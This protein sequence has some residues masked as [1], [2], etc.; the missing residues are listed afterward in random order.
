MKRL[1]LRCGALAVV[2]GVLGCVGA[3]AVLQS[4]G[5]SPRT[6]APY[7]EKRSSGHRPLISDSGRRAGATLDMLD[8][9]EGPAALPALALGARPEA[10]A[11]AV[12]ALRLVGTV[13]EAR[14]AFAEAA[15]GDVITFAPGAYRLDQPLRASRPGTAQAPVTVRARQGGSVTLLVAAQEGIVVQAPHWHV[16]NLVLRGVCRVDDHCEHAFHVVGAGS[17]FVARNNTLEDFNAHLK[18]NGSGGLFP[19][20]GL[21]E[22]NALANTR[23][24]VT[25]NPVTPID[26]VAASG[27]IIRANLISDFIKAGGDR[28]SYGA[29]AKGAGEGNLFERNVVWCEQRLRGLPG[30]RVGLSLGGGGTGKPY[31]RD[32]QCISE[33]QGGIVR[34]N[35]IA[36]CSDV[37]IYLNSAAASVVSHNTVVDTAG[38]DVRF[39][40]SSADLD[41]NLVEGPIRSRNQGILRL[42][43]NRDS[44]VLWSWLGRHPVRSLFRGWER[45]DL[46]WDDAP[47]RRAGTVARVDL[48][49]KARGAAPAYGAFEDFGACLAPAGAASASTS[50]SS[51]AN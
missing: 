32:R 11:E 26:L 40:A 50:S 25:A 16:E 19:D 14:R 45:G 44:P 37:G 7:I 3:A 18:I 23:P 12:G 22:G 47:P 29:F 20:G 5:L 46:A 15:P 41:G 24:R 42:G 34:D 4:Q 13:E 38:I 43:D 35:L 27:W 39:P 2:F 36:S 21:I 48:C 6:L 33:Q 10:A 28:V 8:R 9:G 51:R 49:G 30:Q 17:H 1:L 31:C